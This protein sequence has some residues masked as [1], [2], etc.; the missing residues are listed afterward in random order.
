MAGVTGAST[1]TR[2][3][4]GTGSSADTQ[5][6]RR[7]GA[8]KANPGDARRV[9]RGL[10]LAALHRE[11]QLSRAEL[12]RLSGLT[13]ASVSNVMR[14][15]LDE[16]I[17]AELGQ[18]AGAIGKPATLVGIDPGG[19]DL[20]CV[21]LSDRDELRAAVVDLSGAVRA[22][23]SRPRNGATGEAAVALT[24]ELVEEIAG[25]SDRT[26]L[27]LGVGTP[28]LVDDDGVVRN[29][30]HLGWEETALAERLAS[31]TN[32]AI[33]VENDANAAAAGELAFG[34]G[35][36]RDLLFVRVN[37]GLGAGLVLDGE[38]HRG[39]GFAAGEIGHVVI[40]PDGRPC[41]CGRT[42]CLETI[43]SAPALAESIAGL[44]PDEARAT[45]ADAAGRL[46]AALALV[47]SALDV[48]DVVVSGPESLLDDHFCEAA[49]DAVRA[50]VLPSLA[51]HVH[52]RRGA[53][54]DD[55]V[56]IGAAAIVAARELGIR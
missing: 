33:H 2:S 1:G 8:H 46:G 38:P 30:A 36:H 13:P 12:A 49:Q 17:V 16:G 28:G 37:E 55:A 7:R 47:T 53:H 5:V 35:D 45:L 56:L 24:A 42:G 32:V 39:P 50:R 48:G 9:N 18:V 29:A 22:R 3:G 54:G 34:D 40:D 23:R 6:A 11:G 31:A 25:V 15:L 19:R 51:E 44:G 26:V 14:E 41:P 10:L 27:G 43:I 4:A 52:I 21:D 20:L